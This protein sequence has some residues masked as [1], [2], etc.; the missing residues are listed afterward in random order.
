MS[1][2]TP[3][4][5]SKIIFNHQTTCLNIY[6]YSWARNQVVELHLMECLEQVFY[7]S[8]THIVVLLVLWKKFSYKLY[9]LWNLIQYVHECFNSN[10]CFIRMLHFVFVF[11][12]LIFT[13][14]FCLF[15]LTRFLFYSNWWFGI[16]GSF[17]IN[18]LC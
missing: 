8:I 15:S 13:D 10:V 12:E 17:N 5:V 3:V 9:I 16:C 1:I 18:K 4:L 2:Y 11:S 6:N 7:N 14:D